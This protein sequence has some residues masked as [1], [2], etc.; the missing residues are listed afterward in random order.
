MSRD[1]DRPPAG[2]KWIR[3]RRLDQVVAALDQLGLPAALTA[4]EVKAALELR[5]LWVGYHTAGVAQRIRRA[6]T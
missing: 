1:Y 3:L 5:G 6:R 4:P 2:D